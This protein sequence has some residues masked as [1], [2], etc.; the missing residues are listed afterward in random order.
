[1]SL[2]DLFGKDANFFTGQTPEQRARGAGQIAYESIP[3]VS[4]AVT[5]RD[6]K[7][8]L[9]KENPNWWTIG[10]LGGAG[11]LGI[12]PLV[13]DAAGSAI[14]Q[15]V[16]ARNA[17]KPSSGVLDEVSKA[18]K[19]KA[20]SKQSNIE[21]ALIKKYP[22]VD[23]DIYETDKGLTLSKIVL[24]KEDRNKGIGSKILEDLIAYADKNNLTVGV[25]PD[26]TFG[27]NKN[28]LKSFY[29]KFGFLDNK[30]R[31]KDFTFRE[32]MV[33]QPVEIKLNPAQQQSQDILDLLKSGKADQVTD[34][35]LS[36]A[37]QRYLFENYDLPMDAD[38]LKARA[39]EMGL[40][41]DSFHGTSKAFD[42]QDYPAYTAD[43]IKIPMGNYGN[44]FFSTDNPNIAN[45]YGSIIYPIKTRL[46]DPKFNVDAKGQNWKEIPLNDELIGEF[47]SAVGYEPTSTDMIVDLVNANR[48]DLD[49]V[50]F[51]NVIDR[52]SS[53]PKNL[54][55]NT[56]IN[57]PSTVTAS[58]MD[59][60]PLVRSRF[61][62]F[63]PRLKHL[64]NLSAG[65][66]PIGLLPFLMGDS[67]GAQ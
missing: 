41:T 2:L 26:S 8:E 21:N 58:L 13:G 67:E 50:K 25:T 38:S 54:K 52:G 29:K 57:E 22:N 49:Q 42:S 15:G 30:G 32:T 9:G 10:L 20:L 5:Y 65:L 61:A 37:D 46:K 6:I 7:A 34:Q 3:G 53:Y 28:K 27:G 64:K 56:T 23:L 51:S 45:T 1:L 12:I 33:R 39:K 36:K 47:G 62:R 35:M 55:G 24:P 14:R 18:D 63:D 11:I 16:R 60:N 44:A 19:I 17:V 31:N 4:E 66:V 40:D 48:P 59:H 43:D